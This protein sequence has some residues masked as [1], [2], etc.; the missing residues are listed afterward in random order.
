MEP[1]IKDIADVQVGDSAYHHEGLRAEGRE[2]SLIGKILW[3]GSWVELL[4]SE[5]SGLFA[6]WE[7]LEIPEDE[8]QQMDFVVIDTSDYGP[9]IFAY[10]Y[11]PCSA[12]CLKED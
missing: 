2:E 9:E 7:S 3:K 11:D 4:A 6:D 12:V 10:Q 5:H 1:G 8:Y